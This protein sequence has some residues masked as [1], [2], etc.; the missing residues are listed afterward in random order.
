MKQEM[1]RWPELYNISKVCE[2]IT[3]LEF[4]PALS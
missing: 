3:V 2:I 4:A 1:L